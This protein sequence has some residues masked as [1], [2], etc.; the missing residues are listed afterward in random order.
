MRKMLISIILIMFCGALRADERPLDAMWNSSW[1]DIFN[2]PFNPSLLE[3]EHEDFLNC[4]IHAG[5][6]FI[7]A[8]T[9]SE[10]FVTAPSEFLL[11]MEQIAESTVS[12]HNVA[13]LG[14]IS[15]FPKDLYLDEPGMEHVPVRSAMMDA[16]VS[17][18]LLE[19]MRTSSNRLKLDIANAILEQRDSPSY[20]ESRQKIISEIT[21]DL[22]KNL[23]K[24][25]FCYKTSESVP[26]IMKEAHKSLGKELIDS[27]S[28]YLWVTQ[29]GRP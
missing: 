27:I 14:A 10:K 22:Q 19:T 28:N 20:E 8:K 15:M 9:L 18:R 16:V 5:S 11:K 2:I 6:A 7:I 4:S 12:M 26:E 21:E 23:D 3:Y 17:G 29:M 13:I 25:S 24:L 1:E